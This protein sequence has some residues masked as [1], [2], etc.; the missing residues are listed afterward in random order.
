M[1]DL[2]IL[3]SP[4]MVRATLREI[5]QPGSGK[6]QT[7]RMINPQPHSHM[8]GMWRWEGAIRG[9]QGSFQGSTAGIADSLATHAVRYSAG[10]RLY[11]REAWRT[12]EHLDNFAPKVLPVDSPVF[13]EADAGG[14][15]VGA[16]GK[17]RQGM[18][19]PRWASR[20]TLIVTDVRVQQL[21]EISEA[22]AFAEGIE[23]WSEPG[24]V[25]WRVDDAMSFVGAID[26]YRILWGSLNDK[27]SKPGCAWRDNP[28]IAAYTF[29]PILGNIDQVR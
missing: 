20:I 4:D 19:M 25:S 14:E 21:Q 22:D 10:D 16:T 9:G 5:A 6:T 28:W 1:A 17:F 2:P 15:V 7:R 3:M 11:V 23:C 13:F 18:H 8:P 29:T 12:A 24:L 26:A 27:P